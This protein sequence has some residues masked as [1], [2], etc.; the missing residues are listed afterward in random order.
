MAQPLR[1]IGDPRRFIGERRPRDPS[2]N[3]GV[4]EAPRGET[5]W[6]GR[7]ATYPPP[8]PNAWY[9][10]AESREIRRGESRR[11][12]ALGQSFAVFRDDDGKVGVLDAFCPHLGADLTKGTMDKGRIVCPFHAW[13]FDTDGRVCSAKFHPNIKDSHRARS[14]P[15]EEKLGLI[16]LFWGMNGRASTTPAKPPYPVPEHPGL[17]SGELVHRGRRDAGLVGTH[18]VE[19]AENSV[20]F[21]HFANLHGRM[22]IPW[23]E[24]AVPFVEICHD[25]KWEQDPDHE[26]V[27]RFQDDVLLS[28]AGRKIAKTAGRAIVALHGP[29]SIAE[30][31]ISIP[32]LGE[33]VMYHLHTPVE[34]LT[35]RVRFEWFASKK[36][37]RLLV[38]YIVGSWMSQW[39][40]DVKIWKHKIYREKPLLT[41]DDGPVH[42]VRA[43]FEQFYEPIAD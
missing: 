14:W 27:V 22:N 15:V 11:V 1:F 26:H 18:I 3:G 31:R 39:Q 23:T 19:F 43:W 34:P 33:V 35:Q 12:D 32:E 13:T 9:A 20:D 4:G 2:A 42:R 37:P 25:V 6:A 16:F 5:P 24:L 29:G 17:P 41:K 38:H 10:L 28:V 40:A 8:Y 7:E 21:A 36:M 30:F